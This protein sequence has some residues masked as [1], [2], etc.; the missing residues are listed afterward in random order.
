VVME[1]KESELT[2]NEAETKARTFAYV[3]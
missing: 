1:E 2:R 3:S